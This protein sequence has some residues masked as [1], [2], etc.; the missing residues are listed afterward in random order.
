VAFSDT[1]ITP[2]YVKIAQM[3]KKLKLGDRQTE[4]AYTTLYSCVPTSISLQGTMQSNENTLEMTEKYI[5]L[6]KTI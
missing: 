4:I 2:I 3:V 6:Y 5:S 1:A